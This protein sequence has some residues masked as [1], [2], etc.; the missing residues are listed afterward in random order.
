M[1]A[2]LQAAFPQLSL[3]SW[4][5]AEL[6]PACEGSVLGHQ[7]V[8]PCPAVDASTCSPENTSQGVSRG[9]NLGPPQGLTTKRPILL[10]QAKR[11]GGWASIF[12]SFSRGDVR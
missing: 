11:R 4:G 8:S 1:T 7:K 2:H 5:A 3:P 10:E 12:L 9:S 6:A